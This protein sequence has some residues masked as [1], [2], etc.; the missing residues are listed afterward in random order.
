MINSVF[1]TLKKRNIEN[2]NIIV[3]DLPI[4]RR[5]KY[6]YGYGYNYSYGYG[7]GYYHNEKVSFLKKLQR[8][9]SS[10]A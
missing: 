1:A 3:N 7:Y 10:K 2:I 9:F 8:K 4:L 5:N 6:G